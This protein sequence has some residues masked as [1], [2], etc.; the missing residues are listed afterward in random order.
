MNNPLH[1]AHLSRQ[2]IY[3]A[4]LRQADHEVARRREEVVKIID[5]IEKKIEKEKQNIS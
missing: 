3:Y 5:E 2:R 4:S 1:L